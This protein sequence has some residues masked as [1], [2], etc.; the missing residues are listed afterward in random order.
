MD[1]KFYFLVFYKKNSP[2]IIKKR[3]IDDVNKNKVSGGDGKVDATFTSIIN[4]YGD[5]EFPFHMPFSYDQSDPFLNR[6]IV[7]IPL[8]PYLVGV[9][10]S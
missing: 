8:I 1:P 3:F 7:G 9:F 6:S 4:V 2:T 10:G 5:L